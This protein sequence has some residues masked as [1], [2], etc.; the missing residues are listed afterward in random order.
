[1]I[2]TE[3]TN[4]NNTYQTVRLKMIAF[5][6]HQSF[7]QNHK[8]YMPESKLLCLLSQQFGSSA[9]FLDAEPKV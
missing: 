4:E 1:M 8:Y 5:S 7:L 3:I 2:T 6:I 9:N